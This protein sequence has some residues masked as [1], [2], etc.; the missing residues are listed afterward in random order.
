MP[1]SI[2]EENPSA[3]YLVDYLRLANLGPA[4]A[5]YTLGGEQNGIFQQYIFKSISIGVGGT[6]GFHVQHD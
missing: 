2:Y 5:N 4:L 3:D 6:A 1:L